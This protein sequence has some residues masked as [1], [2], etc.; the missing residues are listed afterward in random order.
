MVDI[1]QIRLHETFLT[2]VFFHLLQYNGCVPPV[3]NE[4]GAC[5][6]PV[7]SDFLENFFEINTSHSAPKLPR[8]QVLIIDL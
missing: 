8:M 2:Y 1:C 6:L 4:R 7:A 5:L 3:L